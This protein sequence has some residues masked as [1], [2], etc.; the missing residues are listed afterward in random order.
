MQKDNGFTLVE[1]MTVIA[2]MAIVSAIA[3]PNFYSYAAGMKLRNAGRDLYSTLQNTRM[4]AIRQNVRWA[5]RFNGAASYQVIDCGTDNTCGTA[6]DDNSGASIRPTTNI[7]QYAGINMTSFP[8][9]VEFYPDG[10]SNGGT[11]NFVDSRGRTSQVVVSVSGR[12]KSS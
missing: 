5:V 9:R 12:V 8:A 4:N 10:T 1:M 2:I 3:I 11:I 7:S 6:D